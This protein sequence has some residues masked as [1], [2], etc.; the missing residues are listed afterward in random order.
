MDEVWTKLNFELCP[1]FLWFLVTFTLKFYCN[2]GSR[3]FWR[4]MLE[5]T[6]RQVHKWRI[7]QH[8]LSRYVYNCSLFAIFLMSVRVWHR[9]AEKCLFGQQGFSSFGISFKN[10]RSYASYGAMSTDDDDD[11]DNDDDYV[12]ECLN[13]NRWFRHIFA[14]RDRSLIIGGG[15]WGGGG[16][17]GG[18][19]A[20]NSKKRLFL[21]RPPQW[22]KKIFRIPLFYWG[23]ISM[24]PP[25]EL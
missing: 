8:A 14:L 24:P 6:K 7:F 5:H 4:C 11:D 2:F 20:K 19:W 21:S 16:G 15:G 10:G 13:S 12:E 25:P 22:R 18:D 17:G 9:A 23:I 1:R 3:Y